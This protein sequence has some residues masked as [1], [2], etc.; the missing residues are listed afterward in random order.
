M[1]FIRGK[2]IDTYCDEM[3]LKTRGRLELFAT[4]CAAVQFAHN[5]GVEN[6]FIG[7]RAGNLSMIGHTNT[8]TGTAAL[9][10]NTTGNNNTAAGA[11]SLTRNESGGENTAV[12]RV[13]LG[14]SVSGSFNTAVG[15]I[16][17]LASTGN[18]N[19]GIGYAA[20]VS[21]NAAA[22][23]WS[24]APVIIGAHDAGALI[25]SKNGLWLAIP[26]ASAAPRPRADGF[27]THPALWEF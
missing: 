20:G 13:A 16:A 14:S 10:K 12:G 9:W 8:A 4:V 18:G 24:K 21:L 2:P 15:G 19:I 26:T 11:E 27:P 17:L 1:E 5:F 7:Q 6:T 25:R 3:G 22:V 23:V